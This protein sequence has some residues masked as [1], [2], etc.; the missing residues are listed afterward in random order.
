MYKSFIKPFLFLFPPETAHHLVASLLKIPG[1]IFLLGLFYK[2]ENPKLE[3]TVFARPDEPFG[4]GLKFP[5]S[6]GLAAGFDKD[7]NI[8]L[9]ITLEKI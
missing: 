1:V 5:N 7:A 6:V 9:G 2:Y 4:R 3:R 8:L